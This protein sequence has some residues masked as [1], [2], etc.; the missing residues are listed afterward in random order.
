MKKLGLIFI[1][2]IFLS[3]CLASLPGKEGTRIDEVPM[4]GGMERAQ[5][6]TLK[7]GDEKFISDVSAQFGSR[8]RASIVW[9]DQAYKF[10]RQNQLGMAMRRFNQA[11]LLNPNNAEVYAGFGAVLMDQGKSCEAMSMMEKSLTLSPP[12]YQGIYA[13]AARIVTLC[14]VNGKDLT[15]DGR[16]KL[17]AR[18]EELYKKAEKIEINKK[19]VY[20]SWAMSRY[21]QGRY[22]DAW[23]MLAKARKIGGETPK[24]FLDLL[25][26]KMP[27]PAQ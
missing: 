17:L 22:D 20:D 27:K 11:W 15:S 1:L 7:A 16:T 4:Y 10:Y 12:E 6:P 24:S 26:A 19:Y 3:G 23:S 2:T 5:Y 14:A 13:D 21:L 8:E 9:V 25:Q 18:S